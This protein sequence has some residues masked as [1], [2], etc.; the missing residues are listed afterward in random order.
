MVILPLVSRRKTVSVNG[1]TATVK[2]LAKHT[3]PED[4]EVRTRMRCYEH[5][6]LALPQKPL[7]TKESIK[8]HLCGIVID[9]AH[10]I[11]KN[12]CWLS[13]IDRPGQSLI[14]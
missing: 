12:Q 11:I 7:G 6:G 5:G 13:S 14:E 3:S 8:H 1:R 9:R 2:Q 4:A 10:H